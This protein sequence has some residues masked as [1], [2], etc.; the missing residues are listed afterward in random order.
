LVPPGVLRLD[1]GRPAEA[2]AAAGSAP[3]LRRPV[4]RPGP[5][6]TPATSWWTARATSDV[7]PG[8]TRDAILAEA[9]P[10]PAQ[11]GGLFDRVSAVLEQL[12]Q[13]TIASSAFRD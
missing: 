7:E 13:A 4:Q 9:P 5:V 12:S 6:G 8:F 11:P 1:L 3:R 10:D 2:A